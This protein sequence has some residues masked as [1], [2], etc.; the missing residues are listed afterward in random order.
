MTCILPYGVETDEP[1]AVLLPELEELDEDDEEPDED[2]PEDDLELEALG[3]L[4][5]EG[6]VPADEP[7]V[8]VEPVEPASAVTEWDVGLSARTPA[9]AATVAPTM[10]AG[11]TIFMVVPSRRDVLA[12]SRQRR[13]P[14]PGL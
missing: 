14:L 4:E 11:L 13:E 9:T 7:P 6:V 12:P 8:S 3:L 5:P 2:D 1:V 10:A